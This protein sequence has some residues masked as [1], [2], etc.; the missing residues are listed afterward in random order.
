MSTNAVRDA[1]F[2][3]GDELEALGLKLKLHLEQEI[4]ADDVDTDDEPDHVDTD[5]EPDVEADDID[6]TF[7]RLGRRIDAAIDAAEA[8][9]GDDAVREDAR[10]TG[11]LLVSAVATTFRTARDEVRR[12]A[13]R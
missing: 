13:K 9:A 12:A 10:E 8:A 4:S 7:E 11:R 3:V 5:G 2:Q 1:W 6:S